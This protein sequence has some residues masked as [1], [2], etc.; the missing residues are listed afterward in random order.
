MELANA[1]RMEIFPRHLAQAK[2][3]KCA[4]KGIS[5]FATQAELVS[6]FSAE[7]GGNRRLDNSDEPIPD[8]VLDKI[9]EVASDIDV[10]H[11]WRLVEDNVFSQEYVIDV[12]EG[13]S[14]RSQLLL[15]E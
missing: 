12:G 13:Y 4:S 6:D 10:A 1:P 8:T 9:H 2:E 14:L 5:E 7:G 3:V 11:G 15:A